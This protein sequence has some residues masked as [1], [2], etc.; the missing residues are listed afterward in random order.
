MSFSAVPSTCCG[1]VS[2]ITSEAGMGFW[3]SSAATASEAFLCDIEVRYCARFSSLLRYVTDSTLSQPSISDWSCST[4]AWSAS[5]ARNAWMVTL[6]S[7]L[8]TMLLST[9]EA[10]TNAPMMKSERKMVTIAPRTVDQF[11]RKW[12]PASRSE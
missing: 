11:L 4:V 6:S 7:T 10:R 9:F 2:L 5:S 12:W 1:S 3:P 8:P